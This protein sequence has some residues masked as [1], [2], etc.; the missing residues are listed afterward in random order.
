ML[1]SRC[2]LPVRCSYRS[3][4]GFNQHT[5]ERHGRTQKPRKILAPTFGCLIHVLSGPSVFFMHS[6]EVF[7]CPRCRRCRRRHLHG[8]AARNAKREAG[9]VVFCVRVVAVKQGIVRK[10]IVKK[11]LYTLL[12]TNKTACTEH[13]HNKSQAHMCENVCLSSNG[14]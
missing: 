10:H 8:S 3:C 6:L 2:S 12:C 4:L 14:A 9:T 1:S 11:V 13:E 5:P 7:G